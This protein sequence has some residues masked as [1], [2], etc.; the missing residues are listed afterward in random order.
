MQKISLKKLK[1]DPKNE[2]TSKRNS[3]KK[4]KE[5]KKKTLILIRF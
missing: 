2:K 1:L 5:K 3:K 4:K